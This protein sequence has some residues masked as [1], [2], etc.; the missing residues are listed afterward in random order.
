[1]RALLVLMVLGLV[2]RCQD[3]SLRWWPE[4]RLRSLNWNGEVVEWYPSGQA[5]RVQ[6]YDALGQEAG[7]QT[8]WRPDGTLHSNYEVRRGRRYGLVN[9]KPCAPH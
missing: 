2:I 9:A 5:F 4:G 8:F 1:M 3:L 6:H 7:M